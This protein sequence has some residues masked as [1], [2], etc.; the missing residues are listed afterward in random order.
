MY[1]NPLFADEHGV[2]ALETQI[3]LRAEPPPIEDQLSIRPHPQA[4]EEDFT[5]KTGRTVHL[6]PIRPEDEPEHHFFI[7]KLSW[8]DIRFHFFGSIGELPHSEMARFAQMDYDREMAF[9]A[10]APDEAGKPETLAEVRTVTDPDNGV[11]EY[12]IIV[13]SDLKG[14]GLGRKLM[15]KIMRNC[16]SRGTQELAGEVLRENRAMLALVKD[17][18][19]SVQGH[20]G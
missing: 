17:T 4:L 18:G 12:S 1:I 6:R 7:S 11:A 20:A 13:R 14:T 10:T 2:L 15:D 3:A 5:L 16:R 9:I 8:E 19:F